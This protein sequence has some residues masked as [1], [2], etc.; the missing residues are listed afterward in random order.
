[1]IAERTH[2][3]LAGKHI[4]RRVPQWKIKVRVE[5]CIDAVPTIVTADEKR[6][7]RRIAL[8]HFAHHP[9]LWILMVKRIREIANESSRQVLNRVLANA[10]NAGNAHP[11]QRIL[12]FIA[13]DFGLF[14]VHIR[15]V[16]AEPSI[17]S[18]AHFIAVRV[19]RQEH[20]VLKLFLHMVLGRAMKPITQRRIT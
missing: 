17:Q 7:L 9:H 10:V 11:P 19:R 1:M 16:I 13:R 15:Q 6:R 18:V 20:A 4:Q 5:L 14:L 3:L 12:N 2:G 8:E